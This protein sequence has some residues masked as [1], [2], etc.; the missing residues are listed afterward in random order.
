MK[1]VTYTLFC[2]QQPKSVSPREEL[3]TATK[4]HPLK[5][6]CRREVTKA[7]QIVSKYK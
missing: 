5:L 6:L 2:Y 1:D 3:L 4:Y 7:I